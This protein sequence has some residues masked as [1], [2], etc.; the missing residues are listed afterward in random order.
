MTIRAAKAQ[1]ALICGGFAQINN[2]DGRGGGSKSLRIR[3]ALGVTA[4]RTGRLV[5]NGVG[6][7]ITFNGT[8][9][10]TTWA[11]ERHGDAEQP[12]GPHDPVRV[13]WPG[14]GQHRP[15]GSALRA[16]AT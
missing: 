15:V 2:V 4:A 12:Y 7:N 5:V 10:W 3:F 16:V 11:A 13:E 6:T 14:P 9:A 1:T 8:G